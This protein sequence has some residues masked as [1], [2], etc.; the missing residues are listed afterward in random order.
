MGVRANYNN[1]AEGVA[2]VFQLLEAFSR[3]LLLGEDNVLKDR[4]MHGVYFYMRYERARS[5]VVDTI[6]SDCLD[7]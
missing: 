7:E 3:N 5:M 6:L 1:L 4:Y 2:A